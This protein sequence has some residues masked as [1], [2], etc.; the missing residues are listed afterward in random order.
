MNG[1]EYCNIAC[2]LYAW[3]VFQW[4]D[5]MYVFRW[6]AFL[7]MVGPP[8]YSV[9]DIFFDR[10]RAVTKSLPFALATAAFLP[11]IFSIW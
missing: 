5:N 9:D 3:I 7:L 2:F 8:F 1:Y 4:N 11:L 10:F 6:Y